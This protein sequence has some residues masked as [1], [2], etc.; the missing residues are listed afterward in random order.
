VEG[1]RT[2][3]RDVEVR[4]QPAIRVDLVRR[5]R[6]DE[7]GG[8]RVGSPLEGG[9]EEPRVRGELLHVGVG[10]RDDDHPVATGCRGGE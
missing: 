8:V 5:K 4:R 9:Q 10:R 2:R 7:A 3:R 6:D 1:A